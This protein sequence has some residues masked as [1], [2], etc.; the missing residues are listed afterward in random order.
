M[1]YA[2]KNPIAYKEKP[3]DSAKMNEEF[4][5]VYSILND[6]EDTKADLASPALTGT[7]TAPTPT[8]GDNSTKVATTAFVNTEISND[9][10][11]ATASP[12][13][14]GTAAVGV[15][16]KV[17]REDHKHP[18]DT[19]RAAS[20][21]T[22]GGGDI[23][24]A[25][26]NATNATTAASCSGNAATATK[27]K[28]ARTISLTGDVTGSASFD[29]S[30]NASIVATVAD[31][32]HNHTIANVDGLQPALNGKA[33]SSHTHGGGDITSAVA[34]A[35]TATK[36]ETARTISLSGDVTG[37]ASFDGSANATITATVADDS[38][39]HTIANVDGLQTAL[40]GKAATS[41]TH[42]YLPLSG[43]TMT[44]VLYPQQNTS[45]T[46]GQARRIILSTGNPS[47]GGN[48]DVWIKYIA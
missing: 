9:R 33:A 23:T 30:A 36:L 19:S 22:H 10:P 21:H 27:L 15:S 46:T 38:H 31:D 28:T 39:N 11:Y 3:A 12:L 6:L 34:N 41:H 13:M 14:D 42:S 44:G 45:Y 37:S 48:G 7:P 1:V 16:A 26:A 2:Q 4:T 18:T 43:G 17:A 32:S 25:V 40:D 20:S 5:Q 8:V 47:G 35:T 29:G 24:S